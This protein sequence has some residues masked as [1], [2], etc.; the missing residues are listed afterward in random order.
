M[1]IV[2]CEKKIKAYADKH[3]KN[4]FAC[5]TPHQAEKIICEF[6]GIQ[7]TAPVAE[8][9]KPSEKNRHI[10][11]FNIGGGYMYDEIDYI[12]ARL[13]EPP[14]GLADWC[15]EKRKMDLLIYKVGY[16]YEPLEDRN[17]KCVKCKCT[18]CGAVTMQEYT[19]LNNRIGFIHSKT[20]E[21]NIRQ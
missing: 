12:L 5:V 9:I 13:N 4:N 2:E 7:I 3:K 20:G 15:N 8:K 17:K 11:R 19:K 14:K 1:S 6:Y 10:G 18:A 21:R 16:Y